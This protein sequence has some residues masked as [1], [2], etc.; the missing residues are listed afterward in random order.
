MSKSAL[1][2]L[3]FI[4]GL[5]GV[6]ML[7]DNLDIIDGFYKLWPAYVM[8]V[9]IGFLMLFYA[10][11]KKDF[12][13]LNFGGYL[14]QFSFLAF[15]CNLN[16]WGDL[17]FLWPVFIGFL[18]FPLLGIY[19]YSGKLFFLISGAF[20]LILCLTFVL[21]FNINAM[22]WPISLILTAVLIFVSNTLPVRNS[23]NVEVENE[24]ESNN[25]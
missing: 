15:Y 23:K 4:F 21:V 5:S 13:L 11:G 10:R 8:F 3:A 14:L 16:S 19:Y 1:N 24:K 9:S 20:A 25:C 12:F 17:S 2:I 22:F 18:G 6:A 7:L